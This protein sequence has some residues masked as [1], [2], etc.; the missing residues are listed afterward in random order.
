MNKS[1]RRR[2]HSPLRAAQA[3][4]TQESI[5][6]GVATWMQAKPHEEL[7]LD[8]IARL[9]G[10]E[11]RTVF[12]YFPTKE[13][14]LAA[15]WTSINHKL[16][17]QTLPASLGE[18]IAAPRETFTQ[19]D[20]EEGLIRASLHS[21]AGREMRLAGVP[22]RQQAFRKALSA[23]TDSIP[24]TERRHL[25]CVA[26]ALYSAATW[27]SMRDYAGVSGKVAGA[28]VTWALTILTNTVRQN[29]SGKHRQ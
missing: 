1:S 2:Y 29:A 16:T 28:A 7:T 10:I 25:E 26:H 13:A 19:F 27:E 9:A 11:R 18:L 14:L 3:R 8:G 6:Q 17:P 20:A 22:A 15:F 24:A 23:V 5:L 12:R 21:S 4:E